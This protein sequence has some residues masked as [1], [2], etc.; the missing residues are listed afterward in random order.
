MNRLRALSILALTFVCVGGAVAQDQQNPAQAP[1]QEAP[2]GKRTM[3]VEDYKQWE[4]LA[5]AAISNDGRFLA[6]QVNKVDADGYSV[7]RKIDGPERSVLPNGTRPAFSDTSKFVGYIYTLPKAEMDKNNEMRRPSPTKLGL[8]NLETGDERTI[9]DI[10]NFDFL[11]DSD[12]VVAL[13]PRMPAPI[14][15]GIPPGPPSPPTNDLLIFN[16]GGGEP[17]V[18]SNVQTY[19][20]NDS[21][22][23]IGVQVT[24]GTGYQSFEVIDVKT[25]AIHPIYTGKDEVVSFSWAKHA[26]VLSLA[27]AKGDEKKEGNNHRIWRVGGFGESIYRQEL[28]PST[29][30]GFP[31]GM[32]IGEGMRV[33]PSEDGAKIA[34]SIL[35]WSDKPKPTNPRDKAGVEIWNTKDIRPMPLQKRMAAQDRGRGM[36]YVWDPKANTLTKA[37]P[38]KDGEIP[39]SNVTTFLSKDMGKAVSIDG[40]PY[41]SPVTNGINYSDVWLTDLATGDKTKVLTKHQFGVSP[42]ETMRYFAYYENKLWWVYDTTTK[43]ATA[44]KPEGGGNFE[45]VLDDHTVEVKPPQSQ[46]I[47]LDKDAGV[48]VQDQYD[49]WLADPATGKMKKLTDGRKDK[50]QFRYI[51]TTPQ[52]DAPKLAYPM[53]FQMLDTE[54]KKGGIYV[55]DEK[56]AGTVALMDDVVVRRLIRAKNAD[57]M[58]FTMES[59]QKSPDVYI[60]NLAF[61]QAK[62]VTKTN[63]QQAG[64]YWGRSEVVSYKSRFGVELQGTL[65]YPANYDPKKKYPMVTYIYERLSDDKNAYQ[66]PLEWSAYN[67]QHFS[68][69]GYFVFE[70]DIAYRS[71]RP[72]ESA[73]ECLE[74]AVDAVLKKNVGVDPRKVGLIGHSWGAYQTAFVTTVSDRFAVGACG[75]P[76]TELTSMYNSFY[77]NSGTPDQV[78][79]ESSQGRMKVPF[80]EDPKAYFDNS[81]VWQSAKRKTP[82]L[83]AFGDADGAVDWH[84][85]QYLFNTLRRMGKTC[86]MLVYAG[87]NHNYTQRPDQL[88]YARRLRHWLDVYLKDAKPEPWVTEGVPFIKQGS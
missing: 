19:G 8:R 73:V 34:I 81:P 85:G 54:G 22:T 72:G 11:K 35:P 52:E 14:G 83:M 65:I 71:N 47:W 6:Y 46:P 21:E 87:E 44:L 1:K 29:F 68:Q 4:R 59:F 24:S 3:T 77:W 9:E 61:T 36:L 38:G 60:T 15:P 31:A 39:A 74:P 26:D 17:I 69:N 2:K 57:R 45:E 33:G 86:V 66:F 16:A 5:L 32:K 20:L 55:V 51:D 42:S 53:H 58:M 25:G 63:P 13:R 49:A 41:A 12:M 37:S 75:A 48:I 18:I 56:G 64:F 62:P 30:P 10:A 23:L 27:I 28:D 40:T 88:D 7:V 76:L 50:V 67:L 79:F 78:I 80:W 70:P 82:L 84:Q 43:K